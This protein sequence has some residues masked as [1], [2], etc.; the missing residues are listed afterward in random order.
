L[1]QRL[2]YWSTDPRINKLSESAEKAVRFRKGLSFIAAVAL[3]HDGR[4]IKLHLRCVGDFLLAEIARHARTSLLP[5]S[6][7]FSDD[8]PASWPSRPA[9]G[10]RPRSTPHSKE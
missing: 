7:V 2:S 3:T 9:V 4:P 6:I 8:W 5:G 1:P 10:A